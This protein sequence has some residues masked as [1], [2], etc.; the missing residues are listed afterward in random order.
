M[1]LTR[2]ALESHKLAIT[3]FTT[4]LSE[5]TKLDGMHFAYHHLVE[6]AYNTSQVAEG[7]AREAVSAVRVAGEKVK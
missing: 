5:M 2:A 4:A 7:V 3:V 1:E 6:N